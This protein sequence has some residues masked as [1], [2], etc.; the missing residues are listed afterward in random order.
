[1][2]LERREEKGRIIW[3]Y[4]RLRI[5]GVVGMPSKSIEEQARVLQGIIP[6]VSPVIDEE[7]RYFVAG[8]SFDPAVD[9]TLA[10][11]KG[12]ES[13]V[14]AFSLG[15]AGLRKIVDT[16]V[17]QSGL[18]PFVDSSDFV[19]DVEEYLQIE[20][21]TYHLTQEMSRNTGRSLQEAFI[22]G[23]YLHFLTKYAGLETEE[24][25]KEMARRF[26]SWP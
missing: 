4:A 17:S 22:I 1:M 2:E 24:I 23:R 20:I 14:L 3:S 18:N 15:E 9:F 13:S 6:K 25:S 5:V 21:D 16:F 8:I 7:Y 26:G 11:D 12:L 10:H 19:E